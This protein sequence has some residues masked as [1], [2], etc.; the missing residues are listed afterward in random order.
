MIVKG[1]AILRGLNENPAGFCQCAQGIA[2]HTGPCI[3]L[4][5]LSMATD[6]KLH[7]N[8]VNWDQQLTRPWY[9]YSKRWKQHRIVAYSA[10]TI[11]LNR[12]KLDPAKLYT[13]DRIRN[14]YPDV[15]SA[16]GY[17]VYGRFIHE[18]EVC[19]SGDISVDCFDRLLVICSRSIKNYITLPWDTA[20]AESIIESIAAFQKSMREKFP[21]IINGPVFL[22]EPE[23]DD[24]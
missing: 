9:P 16:D 17:P 3:S 22:D 20:R 19:Y 15:V 5:D 12:A 21:P 10:V 11:I 13:L 4:S 23:D 2:K 24:G 7:A 6:E 14:T 8:F 1:G 18:C